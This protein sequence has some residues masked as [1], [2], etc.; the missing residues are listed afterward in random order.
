MNH[1]PLAVDVEL[2]ALGFAA[3]YRVI[4]HHQAGRAG[5][6][7]ALKKQGRSEP[8]DASTHHDAIELLAR[9]DRLVRALVDAI[10]NPVAGRHHLVG[11]AVRIRVIADAAVPGPVFFG[12]QLKRRDRLQ[13]NAAC[14]KERCIQKV[15]PFDRRIQ[16]ERVI[17]CLAGAPLAA[18]RFFTFF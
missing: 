11:V 16:A 4:I 15:A 17:M 12:Q 13:Q 10:A 9:I 2:V 14:G 5:P 8:A 7:L 6:A 1:Q 18:A 3:E